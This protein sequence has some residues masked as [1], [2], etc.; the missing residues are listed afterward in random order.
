[1][2]FTEEY[3]KKWLNDKTINPKTNKKIKYGT[4]T[5][6]KIQKLF[7]NYILEKEIIIK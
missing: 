1:M 6:N 3:Y 2:E 7:D 4:R 5:Y